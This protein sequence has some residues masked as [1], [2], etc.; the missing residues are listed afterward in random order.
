MHY[1]A[2][3]TPERDRE[4]ERAQR[5]EQLQ[6]TSPSEHRVR[7]TTA[8]ELHCQNQA[9][10]PNLGFKMILLHILDLAPLMFLVQILVQE[11]P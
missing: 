6:M 11:R 1:R 3:S 7:A 9:P 8:S 4:Q 5:R 10:P 2:P